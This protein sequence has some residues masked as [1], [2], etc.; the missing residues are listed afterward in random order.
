MF[1]EK[2]CRSHPKPAV[3][4]PFSKPESLESGGS[5]TGLGEPQQDLHDAVGHDV[6]A[7]RLDADLLQLG[8]GVELVHAA[9]VDLRASEL[10]DLLLSGSASRLELGNAC[11][12]R[13]FDGLRP[14]SAP[15]SFWISF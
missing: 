14:F 6:R 15:K 4:M 2:A 3:L 11:E 13:Q 12:T 10:G 8:A 9:Q 5:Q 7:L 1:I